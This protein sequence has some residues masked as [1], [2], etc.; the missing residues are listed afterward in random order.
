VL[1]GG[2]S[3]RGVVMAASYEARKFG[4]RSATPVFKKFPEKL[5][6]DR[7]GKFGKEVIKRA[8]LRDE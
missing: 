5:L 7:L 6:L 2:Y 4:V 8:T 1:V 3:N